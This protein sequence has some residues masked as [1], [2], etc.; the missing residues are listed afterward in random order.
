MKT[1]SLIEKNAV[2]EKLANSLWSIIYKM[3]THELRHQA[4]HKEFF[5]SIWLD[6]LKEPMKTRVL[7]WWHVQL[8][9]II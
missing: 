4:F 3:V 9:S 2:S 5:E 6:Y 8:L 7:C 1:P